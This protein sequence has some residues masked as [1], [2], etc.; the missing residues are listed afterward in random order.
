MFA[1][2]PASTIIGRFGGPTKVAALLGIGRVRVSNWKRPKERGGTGGRVPQDHH[3]TLLAAAA[4]LG[5]SLCAE[6]FLPPAVRAASASE[7]CA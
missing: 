1:M 2:E 5:I 3:P 7:G 4:D 6:D